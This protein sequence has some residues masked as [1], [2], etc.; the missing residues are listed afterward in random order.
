MSFEVVTTPT[1]PKPGQFTQVVKKGNIIFIS[2]Q[3]AEPEAAAGNLDPLAQADRIFRYLKD[4]VEAAG[5]AMDDIC[6]INVYL[7]DGS[8]F[9]AILEL[10]PKYFKPPYPAA[11]TIVVQSTVQ[12]ALI[13]EIEAIAILD[14]AHGTRRAGSAAKA[15]NR[16]KKS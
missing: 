10:R 3:T 9:P 4:A 2:G 7:T 16:S 13:M 1:L 14:E 12:R 8:Q 6:K 15:R 5:G 11:T